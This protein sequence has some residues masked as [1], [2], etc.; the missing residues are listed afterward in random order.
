MPQVQQ[1]TITFLYVTFMIFFLFNII[2][3]FILTQQN[4]TTHQQDIHAEYAPYVHLYTSHPRFSHSTLH[5]N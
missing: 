2:L 4:Q 1:E 3:I 5:L